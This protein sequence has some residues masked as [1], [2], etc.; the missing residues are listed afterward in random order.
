MWY[1]VGVM[2]SMSARGASVNPHHH[3]SLLGSGPQAADW[4][5]TWLCGQGALIQQRWLSN[6][7][8]RREGWW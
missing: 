6:H 1:M 3:L 5:L 2:L 4:G 8:L 7:T